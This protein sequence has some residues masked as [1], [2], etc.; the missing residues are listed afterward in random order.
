MHEPIRWKNL[1]NVKW[2]LTILI[3]LYH[4][5][6]HGKGGNEEAIFT[7]IKNLGD[8]VVPAFALI[9]GFLFWVNVKSFSDVRLKMRRR[10]YT[11]LIPY[12]L[13]NVIN[14]IYRNVV[15]ADCIN[16]S[17]FDINIYNNIIK[18]D[19]S[20]HFWYIFMLIFWTILAPVL[21]A[22]YR[23]RKVL[24]V[25]LISQTVYLAY[26]GDGLLHSRFIYILYT[27]GGIVG[28][29]VPD[30][31][32]RIRRLKF[33]IKVSVGVVAGI[34]YVGMGIV[35]S[36]L[37]IGM[38]F[39]VW[40]YALRAVALI[41]A[42]VNLP[43]LRVGEKTDYR[44]SFWLFAVHFWLDDFV[45]RYMVILNVN[46]LLYQV[47]TWVAVVIIGLASGIILDRMCPKCFDL[48]TGN[49]CVNRH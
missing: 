39:K 22:A 13:W 31:F 18:W 15:N 41:L 7:F 34:T 47:F 12:L 26:M 44:Y 25:L 4:I 20:P 36:M 14:T 35:T 38:Q 23:N 28:A 21:W 3:V 2:I 49:R 8:C 48:L 32:E 24:I 46:A 11:L 6:Y 27:W 17:I 19:S 10:V 9:S 42:T 43:L 16:S 45:G 5:Q 1:D 37:D 33:N 40:L 29:K 30:F